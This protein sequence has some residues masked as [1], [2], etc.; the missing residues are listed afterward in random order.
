MLHQA[1]YL[2]EIG[3]R[4]LSQAVSV[5]RP[6]ACVILGGTLPA[7]DRITADRLAWFDWWGQRSDSSDAGFSGRLPTCTDCHVA[8]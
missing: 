8:A 6:K 1:P 4:T 2:A 7:I 5:A 3:F